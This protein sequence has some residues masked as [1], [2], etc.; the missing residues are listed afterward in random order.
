MRLLVHAQ[1]AAFVVQ[2]EEVQ[3]IEITNNGFWLFWLLLA[4]ISCILLVILLAK[5]KK[6]KTK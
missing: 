2:Q 3:E 1:A 5:K 4:C 6:K